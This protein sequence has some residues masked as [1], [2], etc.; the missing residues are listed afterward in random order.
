MTQEVA[1]IMPRHVHM[2]VYARREQRWSTDVVMAGE[3]DALVDI[4]DDRGS[5]GGGDGGSAGDGGAGVGGS[6]SSG[7]GGNARA[8]S[9]SRQGVSVPASGSPVIRAATTPERDAEER[10]RDRDEPDFREDL[11]LDAD[12]GTAGRQGAVPAT[13]PSRRLRRKTSLGD[14]ALP[15]PR[16]SSG[17]SPRSHGRADLAGAAADVGGAQDRDRKSVV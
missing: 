15:P 13:T 4:V 2:V 14:D 1:H 12:C 9:P 17:Q 5:G 3:G 6:S 10:R 11:D 16:I 8:A 7:G